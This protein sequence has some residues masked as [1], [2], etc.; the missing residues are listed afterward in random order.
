MVT[1]SWRHMSLQV[2]RV[3]LRHPWSLSRWPPPLARPGYPRNEKSNTADVNSASLG[4]SK[5]KI[6]HRSSI[7]D[8]FETFE[9]KQYANHFLSPSVSLCLSL[10]DSSH[11]TIRRAVAFYQGEYPLWCWWVILRLKACRLLLNLLAPK[12]LVAAMLPVAQW[13][14]LLVC[15]WW[16]PWLL[17]LMR[18]F[19]FAQ[20]NSKFGTYV[21]SAASYWAA[22]HGTGNQDTKNIK[23]HQETPVPLETECRWHDVV[24]CKKAWLCS[25]IVSCRWCGFACH[26][27]VCKHNQCLISAQIYPPRCGLLL[28]S[29]ITNEKKLT[30]IMYT[31]HLSICDC[32]PSP[33]G[34]I[35]FV[36]F[37]LC[38]SPPRNKHGGCNFQASAAT[39]MRLPANPCAERLQAPADIWGIGIFGIVRIWIFGVGKLVCVVFF[40]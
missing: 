4:G 24:A 14:V 19:W 21:E 12:A 20:T 26:L 11:I 6:F 15:V 5:V 33:L 10:F 8:T 22:W 30:I 13:L 28:C 23:K 9:A 27:Q 7:L 36:L 1:F 29:S 37:S 2:S 39:N 18:C 34:L 40:S 38:I 3:S 16:V 35:V 25:Q 31:L 17:M 32:S